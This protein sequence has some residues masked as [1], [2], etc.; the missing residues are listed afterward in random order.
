MK[1]HHEDLD[2]SNLIYSEI[3][4]ERWEARK[5]EFVPG[6]KVGCAYDDVEVGG[7]GLGLE[8]IP[9]DFI[10]LFVGYYRYSNHDWV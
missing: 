6:D 1:W 8:P 10:A 2:H 5:L 9:W 4:E 3:D 7:T